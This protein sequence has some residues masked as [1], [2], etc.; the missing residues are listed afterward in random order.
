LGDA[1]VAIKDDVRLLTEITLFH[2]SPL[3]DEILVG[4]CLRHQ[5]KRSR[6]PE[7]SSQGPAAHGALRSG[8]N[9]HTRASLLHPH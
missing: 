8:T 5:L 4:S 3:K 9:S 6:V 1:S 7:P 2:F